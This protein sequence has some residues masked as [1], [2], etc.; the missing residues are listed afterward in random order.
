[1]CQLTHLGTR[2]V[3]RIHEPGRYFVYR[4]VGYYIYTNNRLHETGTQEKP[5]YVIRVRHRQR[6]GPIK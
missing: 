2:G 3:N 1:M 5:I 4:R 6:I